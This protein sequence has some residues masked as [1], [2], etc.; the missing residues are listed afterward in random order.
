MICPP[1]FHNSL[2]LF[3]W[4][5][6]IFVCLLWLFTGFA[7]GQDKELEKANELY[8]AESYAEAAQLFEKV[9]ATYSEKKQAS[10]SA[11]NLKTK[12][13]RCYS[14]NNRHAEAERLYAEIVT[15]ED[16]RPKVYFLYAEVLMTNGKYDQ[17]KEWLLKYQALE[18]GNPNIALLLRSCE[19]A[20]HI[21]PYFKSIG[22]RPFAHNSDADDNSPVIWKNGILFS[23]DRK[24]G[25]KLLKEKS[26][27]TGRDF[28]D[29][30]YS[31]ALPDGTYASP[32]QFSSKLSVL[33]KNL[34]NASISTD[35]STI[36][37]TRND[38]EPNKREIY[39]LQLYYAKASGDKWKDVEKLPFCSEGFNFMHPAISP[40]GNTLFFTSD[41]PGGEG[42][43]DLWMSR[44]IPDGWDRPVNLG[45][46][47]NTP[48]NEG[49]PFMSS[50]GKLFFCSKGHPGL[51]GF[52]IFVTRQNPNGTWD[53]PINLGPPINSSFDD[54]S[55]FLNDDNVSGVF[56]S[57]RE[58]GDDDIYF[59]S[60]DILEDATVVQENRNTDDADELLQPIEYTTFSPSVNDTTVIEEN[61]RRFSVET[62]LPNSDTEMLSPNLPKENKYDKDESN[63]S[64]MQEHQVPSKEVMVEP[65]QKETDVFVENEQEKFPSTL[66]HD[67]V[68][69][70]S[71]LNNPASVA[72]APTTVSPDSVK[73]PIF[74]SD[75]GVNALA[76]SEDMTASETTLISSTGLFAFQEL[77]RKLNLNSLK[78][79]DRFRLD[80]AKYDV[81]VWQPTP[82]V[83]RALDELAN[84]M[85][86]KPTFVIEIGAHTESI[87]SDDYNLEL[88]KKRA[89]LARE[90]LLREGIKSDRIIAKGYG[91]T[92]LLNHCANGVDCTLQEH[93]L[94]QRLEV[95]IL[96][97]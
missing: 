43:T 51:G 80:G 2:S 23:S 87:G 17:A 18:P 93:L 72:A 32:E 12:L 57:S 4:G 6:T 21:P 48:L 67:L 68:R 5:K 11:I 35:G 41:K 90:Y 95:K 83:A 24:S 38:N 39:N 27:W 75:Q 76:A 10:K 53:R 86:K 79:G 81:N 31:S 3:S 62:E 54:I 71:E 91:E 96:K 28:L 60:P 34:G 94:N 14:M 15:D 30:Y 49:F 26:G 58:G 69:E 85:K 66:E 63:V 29:L 46:T 70:T 74:N 33:N 16:V 25:V 56:T 37:F 36:Y 9:L 44:R 78:I 65:I 82:Q 50:D 40:D 88:S 61:L 73:D 47:I 77:E 13:A 19:I 42:G 8:Q 89:E 7:Y 1:F 22:V 52:D 20:P 55:I 59:F 64:I 45:S 84:V 92:D 97:F